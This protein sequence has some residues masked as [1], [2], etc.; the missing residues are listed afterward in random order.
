[1]TTGTSRASPVDP[2][3][4]GATWVAL[5]SGGATLV[6]CALPALLV[7]IGAGAALAGLVSAFPAIV[8]LSESK[9]AVFGVAIVALAIAGLLQWRTRGAPCPA[10]PAP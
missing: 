1:M 9:A 8:W 6:C 3:T 2:G 10:D 5:A 4:R 7:A